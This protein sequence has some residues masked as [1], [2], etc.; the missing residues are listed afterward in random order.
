MMHDSTKKRP[1]TKSKRGSVKK[2]KTMRHNN[3]KHNVQQISSAIKN[4]SF[5]KARSDF[6]ALQELDF[7]KTSLQVQQ[8][9]KIGNS[10]MDYYFFKYR[11]HT[12]TKRGISYYEW[13]KT[14]WQQNESEYRMYKFNLAQGKNHEQ[15]R[16]GVFRLYYGS[17]QGFKPTIAKWLYSTYA[18]KVAALDFSA[19]WGGRC[20]AA[21]SLGIPYIG[22]DT[23]TSLR[24]VYNKMIRELRD[25]S[26]PNSTNINITMIF[27]DAATVDY[28]K[29]SYDM[30]FTSPPYF[31]KFVPAEEYPHM[32]KYT[33]RD[34]FNNRFL[35]PT[36]QNTFMHLKRGGTFA[37]NIPQDA[38]RDIQQA[39]ILPSRLKAKHRL[40]IQPRFAKGN[41]VH[42]ENQYKE[43]I[44]VWKK[45][46]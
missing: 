21:M 5:E 7:S 35:F 24:P 32:P 22:I 41:P 33:S 28:S 11:L 4:I 16:Y 25:I 46:E 20:L 31:K 42:P 37:I 10:V 38:Y 27:K 30:V 17:T 14:R 45:L 1:K 3:N 18:P 36:I 6:K 2:N 19:G 39:K 34:D 15:A 29:Y 23:N 9:K 13:I 12:K 40:F 44:Y 26:T 8:T 43:Y